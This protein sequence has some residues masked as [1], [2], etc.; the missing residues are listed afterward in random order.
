MRALFR[1]FYHQAPSLVSFRLVFPIQDS[2]GGPEADR[3][4]GT[5]LPS[6]EYTTGFDTGLTRFPTPHPR[7][8]GSTTMFVRAVE[9]LWHSC[10]YNWATIR[11]N[12][13]GEVAGSLGDLGTLLPIMVA[14]TAAQSISLTSTLIFSGIFNI[15]SG[16][17]FGI[18]IVVRFQ[19]GPSERCHS[20]G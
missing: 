3:P 9:Y 7:H 14:L 18:P 2:T 20:Y 17:I 19:P 1:S 11:N 5:V 10:L 6:T 8:R 15:M 13:L 16:T 12:A 4:A